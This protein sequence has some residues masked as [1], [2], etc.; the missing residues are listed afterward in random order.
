MTNESKDDSKVYLV[1]L[2]LVKAHQ[3]GRME[4]GKQI[5]LF[6]RMQSTIFR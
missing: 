2:T 3:L 6:D 4:S 1:V 5:N